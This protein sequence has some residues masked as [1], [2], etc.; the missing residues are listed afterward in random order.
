[1]A[2]RAGVCSFMGVV[3]SVTNPEMQVG[4]PSVDLGH[5]AQGRGEEFSFQGKHKTTEALWKEY[6]GDL[7]YICQISCLQHFF[8]KL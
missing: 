3:L 8:F 2:E 1:M 5:A 7:R 4:R 6:H